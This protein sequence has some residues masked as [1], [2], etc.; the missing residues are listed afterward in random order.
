V[1]DEKNPASDQPLYEPIGN[2]NPRFG[3]EDDAGGNPAPSGGGQARVLLRSALE[4]AVLAVRSRRFWWG[5]A[6]VIA[7]CW[8]AGV[9][10]VIAV[11]TGG[12]LPPESH[13]WTYVL[14]AAALVLACCVLAVRWGAR[15]VG[16]VP[17]AARAN[18][19]GRLVDSPLT[20]WARASAAGVIF[21]A[22]AGVFLLL[23]ASWSGSSPAVAGVA[24]VLM[25]GESLAFSGIGAGAAGWF[26]GHRGR[27]LGWAVAGLL[28]LGNIA[29]VVA[30]LP[31]VRAYEPV[32]VAINIERDDFGRVTSYRCSREFRGFAEVYHTERIFWIATSNP[33]VILALLAGE[34]EP[35]ENALDWLPGELQN[36]AEG[37]QVPCLE[38]EAAE[39]TG[40]EM[41]LALLGL[42]IQFGAAGALLAAGHR[43]SQRRPV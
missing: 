43:A 19:D 23:L 42:A 36:A 22:V 10:L 11:V 15:R 17:G 37:T 33:L 32:L 34:A 2:G 3:N 16:A 18:P 1:A 21:A 9:L 20:G 27:I 38:G 13:G 39:K 14:T 35:K 24:F 26:G 41:P 6:A 5:I 7:V 29:A 25:V 28:L 31:A 40:A 8:G 30:L 4:A 12:D